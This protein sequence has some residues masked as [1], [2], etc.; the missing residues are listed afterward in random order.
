MV[1]K[2]IFV[3]PSA[4][5]LQDFFDAVRENSAQA[6][7][8]GYDITAK[9]IID[10][11]CEPVLFPPTPAVSVVLSWSY[12]MYTE[13]YMDTLHSKLGRRLIK[14]LQSQPKE[15]VTLLYEGSQR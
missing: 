1:S 4:K 5:R 6:T 8:R 2:A 13:G 12:H 7:V 14:W 3:R 9:E 15:I 10:Y 11:I